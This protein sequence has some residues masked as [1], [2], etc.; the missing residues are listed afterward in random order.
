MDF[1]AREHLPKHSGSSSLSRS[2][3]VG[4]LVAAATV[5]TRT[6]AERS[7]SAV[8]KRPPPNKR[9]EDDA[10]LKDA[11]LWAVLIGATTGLVRLGVRRAARARLKKR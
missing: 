11:V 2:L 3:I 8:Y 7:W 10:D 6:A 4:G 5:A 9:A 1:Q